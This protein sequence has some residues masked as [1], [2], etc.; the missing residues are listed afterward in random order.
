MERA[1][2]VGVGNAEPLVEAAARG[3]ELRVVAEV[4]RMMSNL[5]LVAAG[6]GVSVVPASMCAITLRIRVTC[7]SR[8]IACLL[9]QARTDLIAADDILR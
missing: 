4:P 9:A 5:N 7:S 2:V 6:A 8:S 1:V 3:E